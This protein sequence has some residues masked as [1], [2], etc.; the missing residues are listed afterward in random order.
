MGNYMIQWCRLDGSIAFTVFKNTEEDMK[1][2]VADC[3]NDGYIAQ[4]GKIN[5]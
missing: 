4:V 2:E 5:K 1:Q 3:V